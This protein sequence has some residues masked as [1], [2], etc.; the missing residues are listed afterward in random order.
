MENNKQLK[1]VEECLS[2]Q[3]LLDADGYTHATV[4]ELSLAF[5]NYCQIQ[6]DKYLKEEEREVKALKQQNDEL[7]EQTA[8]LQADK[9]RMAEQLKEVYD[10]M[11]AFDY[12]N[13]R[14]IIKQTLSE[15]GY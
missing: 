15:C 10:V 6:A 12:P 14:K 8:K 9:D 3:G 4:E 5:D 2:A 13:T 11:N 1:D 7:I